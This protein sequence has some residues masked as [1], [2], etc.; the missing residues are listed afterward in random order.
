MKSI[1]ECECCGNPGRNAIGRPPAYLCGTHL[2]SFKRRVG[3]VT[4]HTY[5][6]SRADVRRALGFVF[7]D[8]TRESDDGA[9]EG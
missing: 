6:W 8:A 5:A 3:A 1:P 7:P 4:Y 9:E 2:N